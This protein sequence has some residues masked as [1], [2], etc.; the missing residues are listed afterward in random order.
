M[1][2]RITYCPIGTADVITAT[3]VGYKF[4]APCPGNLHIGLSYNVIETT[5]ATGTALAVIALQVVRGSSTYTLGTF[6]PANGA[7]AFETTLIWTP[8]T[9]ELIG[10]ETFNF[11]ENPF[12][13]LQTGDLIQTNVTTA[14]TDG[15]AAAGAYRSYFVI[16][17]GPAT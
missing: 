12:F 8:D 10:N 11:T 14:G 7:V 17:L 15:T 16:D 13:E 5:V 2:N 1:Q 3:G 6:S 4:K 9:S